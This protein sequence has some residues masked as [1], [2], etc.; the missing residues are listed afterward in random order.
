MEE[1]LVTAIW[2]CFRAAARGMWMNAVVEGQDEY[3]LCAC[4][5]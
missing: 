4:L 3:V 2:S 5:A 1:L